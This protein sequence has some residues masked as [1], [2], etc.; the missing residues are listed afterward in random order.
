MAVIGDRRSWLTDRSSAVLMTSL[1]RSARVSTTSPSSA[2]RSWA[3]ASNASSC[4]TARSCARRSTSSGRSAG[5]SSVPICTASSRSGN[6]TRRSSPSTGRSSIA[7]DG[8]PSAPAR[9]CEATGRTLE[10]SSPAEQQPGELR[11]EIGLATAL[12]GLLRAM[13]R[14]LR[15]R[16]GDERHDQNTASATQFC[17]SAI[18]KRPVGGRWNQLKASAPRIAVAVPST[19]APSD[20]HHEDG[21]EVDDDERRD[22]R[23]LLQRE[24]DQRGERDAHDRGD[25]PQPG[26]GPAVAREAERVAS[27]HNGERRPVE[28][29]FTR[30]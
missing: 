11:G 21:D 30:S 28:V 7:A 23:D 14:R 4:G 9:R 20:G 15:E 18:V 8:T 1:R 2:S 5:S 24:D 27:G 13:A 22:G 29:V 10:R 17:A 12:L 19:R 3:A 16:A 25:D 26:A 6:A